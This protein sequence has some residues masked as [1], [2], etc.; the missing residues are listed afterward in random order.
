MVAEDAEVRQFQ[1]IDDTEI[2]LV[3]IAGARTGEI[4]EIREEQR[5]RLESRDLVNELC[6]DRI[7]SWVG[8]GS[9]IPRDYEPEGVTHHGILDAVRHL[10]I[11][12]TIHVDPHKTR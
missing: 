4:P 7:C 6:V 8:P 2:V 10:A 1:T 5:R 11:A 9:A 3:T 12:I